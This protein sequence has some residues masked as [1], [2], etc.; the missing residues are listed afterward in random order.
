MKRLTCEMCGSTN[1]VKEDGVFVCQSCGVKYSVE[2]A[3]KMMVEGVVE[4]TGT[5]KI[6]STDELAKFYQIARRAKSEGNIENAARYYDLILQK[7]PDDWEAYFYSVYYQT[8]SV[9][10]DNIQS[11]AISMKNCAASTVQMIKNDVKTDQNKVVEE[12]VNKTDELVKKLID[13]LNK[14]FREQEYTRPSY[15]LQMD[16]NAYMKEKV[17]FNQRKGDYRE[18]CQACLDILDGLGTE[19]SKTFQSNE[20]MLLLAI[21]LFQNGDKRAS[22]SQS[23][24]VSSYSYF[25]KAVELKGKLAMMQ[26][27]KQKLQQRNNSNE[28]K[29]EGSFVPKGS[30]LL[31]DYK[32]DYESKKNQLTQEIQAAREKAFVGE[33]LLDAC[34]AKI[35]FDLYSLKVSARL[36]GN[37][38]NGVYTNND[39]VEYYKN[40][41]NVVLYKDRLCI[42]TITRALAAE[43]FFNEKKHKMVE[44]Q[45]D[46]FTE[47]LLKKNSS[48]KIEKYD[49]NKPGCYVATCVYGSYDCPEVWTLRRYRD[50]TLGATWY[51]RA[52]IRTYYAISPTLVKWFGKTKWFK[53]MWKGKLDKK[54]KKLQEKGVESTPYEDKPW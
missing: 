31:G 10:L 41:A 13:L 25:S 35:Y 48:V 3:K 53:K 4:V 32:K 17:L 19:I 49:T 42:G 30:I 29:A 24:G 45:F 1:L 22:E 18:K 26:K 47:Q 20:E 11:A 15:N 6:D 28:K 38:A 52:F 14:S 33:I 9:S 8:M 16:A 7:K 54:V 37:R 12:I 21:K 2:E 46:K 39:F 34:E 51:G 5:V 43:I 44:E 23:L 50:D 36:L 27:A 40:I